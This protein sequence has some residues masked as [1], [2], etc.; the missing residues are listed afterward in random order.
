MMKR[1]KAKNNP[2]GAIVGL[3][4]WCLATL[5]G[6]WSGLEPDV[7]LARGVVAG[8]TVGLITSIFVRFLSSVLVQE[9]Q[10]RK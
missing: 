2:W 9:S 1:N 8:M 10:R 6:V 5:A 4:T 3:S 7:I